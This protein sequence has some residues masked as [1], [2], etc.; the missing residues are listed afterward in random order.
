[1]SFVEAVTNVAVGFLLALLTQISD[2]HR[3][4]TVPHSGRVAGALCRAAKRGTLTAPMP[5][6]GP[7]RPDSR[8]IPPVPT[9]P[10]AES[11]IAPVG[12]LWGVASSFR[13]NT[14]RSSFLR[15]CNVK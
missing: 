10:A 5:L 11:K 3:S 13:S 7:E 8:D 15:Y 2:R 1:M 4:G 14:Q 9:H 12:R 6:G